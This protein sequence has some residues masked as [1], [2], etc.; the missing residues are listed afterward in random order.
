[1][2]PIEHKPSGSVLEP[3]VIHVLVTGFGPF[4][5]YEEN[6]S[7]LAVK[8]LHNTVIYTEPQPPTETNNQHEPSP[9]YAEPMQEDGPATLQQIHITTLII[10]VA[11]QDVLAIT[12]GLHARPPVLP[13]PADPAFAPTHLPPNGFDFIFHVGV[14][15]RGPLRIERLGHKLNY[16]MKDVDGQYAPVVQLPKE[17]APPQEPAEAERLEMQRL[18]S[19]SAVSIDGFPSGPNGLR[20]SMDISIANGERVVE[21]HHQ[22]HQPARGFGKG[23]EGFA[24]ELFTELDVT[25]LIN[26]LKKTG[27]EQV[28]SSMDAGHY[29]CDFLFY[30]SLAEAKRNAGKLE[31]DKAR[32]TPPKMTPVLFMHCCPVGQPME[33]AEVTQAIKQIIVWVCAR[34]SV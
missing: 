10:P 8:P 24:D 28:Y 23:Y 16:R 13:P 31:K 14:A 4:W 34:L 17:P 1:M 22:E 26:H 29:L 30:C 9:S 32:S 19:V 11:Y 33:T 18:L 15:G 20:A 5:K 21:P 3:N 7:W 2:P 25:K 6:P 12:A 27:I